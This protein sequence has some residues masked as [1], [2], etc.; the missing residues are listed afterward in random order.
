MAAKIRQWYGMT[1]MVEFG[2]ILHGTSNT[3]Q[4]AYKLL[5][6]NGGMVEPVAIASQ[7]LEFERF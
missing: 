2:I 4:T 3:S 6:P 7:L 5:F 1:R